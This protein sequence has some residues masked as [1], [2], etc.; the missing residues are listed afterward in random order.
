[1]A[2]G[3]TSSSDNSA[4]YRKPWFWCIILAIVAIMG[5]SIVVYTMGMTGNNT[6]VTTVQNNRLQHEVQ[7]VTD[8][9]T[10][11]VKNVVRGYEDEDYDTPL[12]VLDVV[13]TNNTG[14]S[15]MVDERGWYGLDSNGNRMEPVILNKNY[16]FAK[17]M[18]RSVENNSTLTYSLCFEGDCAV[19][20]RDATDTTPEYRFEL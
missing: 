2:E 12:T 16:V 6:T 17:P 1:M 3:K 19:V 5:A 13:Y 4:L 11:S 14:S 9:V 15:Q 10:V 20:C 18:E 8:A 7:T